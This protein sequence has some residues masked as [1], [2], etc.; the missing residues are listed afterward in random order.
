MKGN[1]SFLFDRTV[2]IKDKNHA[3]FEEPVSKFT[4]SHTLNYDMHMCMYI[5]ACVLIMHSK[6]VG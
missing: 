4:V 3:V 5:L 6:Y 2:V 1:S